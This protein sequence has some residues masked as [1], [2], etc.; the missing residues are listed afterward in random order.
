MPPVE[1]ATAAQMTTAAALRQ[2]GYCERASNE[3]ELRKSSHIAS[4]W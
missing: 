1:T 3:E 2:C 4:Q